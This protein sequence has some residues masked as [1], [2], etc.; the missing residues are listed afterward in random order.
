VND[1]SALIIGNSI[2]LNSWV[3][4]EIH[5]GLGAIVTN[6]VITRRNVYGVSSGAA[7]VVGLVG[8]SSN[9]F[10]GNNHDWNGPVSM[11]NNVCAAGVC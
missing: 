6:N 2:D 11:K 5:G 10:A 8:L 4:V 7:V 3:G 1:G 9:M